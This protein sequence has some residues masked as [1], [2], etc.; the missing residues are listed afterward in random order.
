M[1]ASFLDLPTELR[2]KCI[3]MSLAYAFDLQSIV[4]DVL[5]SSGMEP[6]QGTRGP[7][8]GHVFMA[9]TYDSLDRSEQLSQRCSKH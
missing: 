6:S 8:K 2:L 1:H 5:T 9:E 3:E 7:K 4:N